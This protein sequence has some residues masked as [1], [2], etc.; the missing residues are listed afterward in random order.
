V[1]ARQ[2][3]L[4][5]VELFNRHS[6]CFSGAIAGLRLIALSAR[7]KAR[8]LMLCPGRHSGLRALE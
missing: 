5:P 4:G 1:E 6:G 8:A 3:P 7:M 2:H